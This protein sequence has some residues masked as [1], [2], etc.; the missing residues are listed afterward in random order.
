MSANGSAAGAAR[1]RVLERAF[2]VVERFGEHD[3]A[4][5]HFGIEAG[6]RGELGEPIDRDVHLHR[7]AARCSSRYRSPSGV[8]S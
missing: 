8:I 1:N 5:V 4:A 6:L 7:A 3:R 2:D